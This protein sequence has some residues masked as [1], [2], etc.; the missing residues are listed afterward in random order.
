[1]LILPSERRSPTLHLVGTIGKRAGSEISALAPDFIWLS[2][3][4]LA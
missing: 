2:L 3:F 4:V 1:M